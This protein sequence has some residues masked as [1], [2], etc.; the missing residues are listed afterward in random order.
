M[1]LFAIEPDGDRKQL[2][3]G[4]L[5][6]TASSFECLWYINPTRTDIKSIPGSLFWRIN[7][8]ET[9]VEMEF[10][11]DTS[12]KDFI[13]TT[14]ENGITLN[15]LGE[16]LGSVSCIYGN[17]NVKIN[18]VTKGKCTDSLLCSVNLAPLSVASIH[19]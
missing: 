5:I 8:L 11:S 1:S 15:I 2:I 17:D 14:L 10:T 16:F 9:K 3:D 13:V 4:A 19:S 6:N 18:A 12:G 7:H